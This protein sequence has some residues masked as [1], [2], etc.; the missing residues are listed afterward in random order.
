MRLTHPSL[1]LCI[2]LSLAACAAS[3]AAPD[4][5]TSLPRATGV[6]SVPS[7]LPPLAQQQRETYLRRAMPP[8]PTGE[9]AARY[10]IVQL[11]ERPVDCAGVAG[12]DT[13]GGDLLS[14]LIALDD[15]SIGLGVEQHHP[16]ELD[17]FARAVAGTLAE[18]GRSFTSTSACRFGAYTVLTG[19]TFPKGTGP[20][21]C[22]GGATALPACGRETLAVYVA[23][24][25]IVKEGIPTYSRT[26][27]VG[28]ILP[29]KT[30]VQ[31]AE[32]VV[33]ALLRC[34]TEAGETRRLALPLGPES[35]LPPPT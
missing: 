17:V 13:R 24:R 9:G 2:A 8:L 12:Q 14:T 10:G 32:G 3:P 34:T 21:D 29:C 33:H 11:A 5:P 26:E 23:G 19:V 35:E 15:A 16:A 27:P 22:P 1:A 4:H 18:R 30:A 20:A 28:Q 25:V 31:V 6:P 7:A